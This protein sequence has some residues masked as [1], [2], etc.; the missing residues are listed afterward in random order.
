MSGEFANALQKTD[1]I[2]LTVTGRVTGREFSFPVWFVKEKEKFYLLPVRGSD[3][4]WYKNML[5]TPRMRLTANG[6]SV[7]ATAKPITDPAR[8]SEVVDKF[9][10]NY[11]PDQVAQNY[12]KTDVAVDVGLPEAAR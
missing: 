3:S 2:E 10:A 8:V 7:T 12:P 1:Q 11:G 5:K 9:R 4:D 6:A